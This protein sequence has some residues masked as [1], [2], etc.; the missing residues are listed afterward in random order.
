MMEQGVRQAD[1]NETVDVT[2]TA[3][4]EEPECY[5]QANDIFLPACLLTCPSSHRARIESWVI[6]QTVT[7]AIFGCFDL[8]LSAS[9]WAASRWHSDRFDK[10]VVQMNGV[11]ELRD[12]GLAWLIMFKRK[13]LGIQASVVVRGCRGEIA[14]RCQ[15]AGLPFV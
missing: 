12:S 3:Q 5:L 8:S 14:S 1:A 6:D 15:A 11:T 7:I 4:C 2:Q 10:Y 13:T 9:L